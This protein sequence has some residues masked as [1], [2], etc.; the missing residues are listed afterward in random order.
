MSSS[1]DCQQVLTI[2]PLCE[3]GSPTV[4]DWRH[5]AR[6]PAQEPCVAVLEPPPSPSSAIRSRARAGAGREGSTAPLTWRASMRDRDQLRQL[7][8]LG[9]GLLLDHA[10]AAAVPLQ[11]VLLVDRAVLERQQRPLE[12]AVGRPHGA[13]AA[14]H[15]GLVHGVPG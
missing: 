7:L 15:L 14:E 4:D 13:A 3:D 10:D 5:A 6:L 11:L 1:S 8:A 2:S 9:D 12:A